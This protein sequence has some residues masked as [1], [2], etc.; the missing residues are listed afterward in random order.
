M[1]FVQIVVFIVIISLYGVGP[2]GIGLRVIKG[3]VG[4]HLF[5]QFFIYFHGFTI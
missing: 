2:V 5:I 3:E 1:T 4:R